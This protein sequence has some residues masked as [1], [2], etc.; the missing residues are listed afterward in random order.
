MQK[1][2]RKAGITP[3]P[4]VHVSIKIYMHVLG[5]KLSALIG[6][7]NQSTKNNANHENFAYLKKPTH[8]E[9]SK[10]RINDLFRVANTANNVELHMFHCSGRSVK[11]KRSTGVRNLLWE[12]GV[13]PVRDVSNQHGMCI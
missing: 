2:L 6:C 7:A 12:T 1:Q 13:R 10:T 3:A 5:K 8:A 11:P 4:D 9:G